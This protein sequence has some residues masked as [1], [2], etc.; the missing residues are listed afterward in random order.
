MISNPTLFSR[1]ASGLRGLAA[2]SALLAFAAAGLALAPAQASAAAPE[3]FVGVQGWDNPTG[4]QILKLRGAK[5]Q[6][7]RIQLNWASV[8]KQKPKEL[9]PGVPGDCR[10]GTKCTHYYDWTG[11]DRLF[12]RAAYRGIR[13][14]PVLLGSPRWAYSKP[15]TPPLG[16][17]G[18]RSYFDFAKAATKRYGPNGT[19]WSRSGVPK[20]TR[21]WYW[22]IW[23]EPNLPNYWNGRPN[24]AEYAKFLSGASDA[25]NRGDSDVQIVVGGLPYSTIRG[26]I[27]PRNFLRGMFR[28]YPRIDRKFTAVGLH[29]YASTPSLVQEAIR[30]MR[31]TM[32]DIGYMGDNPLYITEMGW[33]TGPRDGRFQVS[34]S[35]QASYLRDIFGRLI[36][37]RSR[38]N[39]KGAFWFSLI[40]VPNPWFWG[41]RT[42]LLRS[43]G[44]EKPS[45]SSLERVT[46]AQ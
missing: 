11:Y 33:A 7:Y 2:V 20:E 29:P 25:A 18:R 38:W 17:V 27:D 46:G 40:D 15:T 21:A 43:N 36:G 1:P 8:E 30:V 31:V 14:L 42:G 26:T 16:P 22:Q 4:S 34:E 24:P 12:G 23:N 37:A 32:N 6:S 19:F 3:R 45:W 9:R 39:I 35:T 13:M 28:A 5:V 44:S 41:E 10:P